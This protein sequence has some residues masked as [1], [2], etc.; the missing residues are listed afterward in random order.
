MHCP[1]HAAARCRSCTEL[2]VPYAAQLDAKQAHCRELLA[3]WPDLDWLPPVA[4]R[5]A[6]F[7]NKAKMVVS[8]SAAAPVL[9]IRD[10]AGRGVDLS[11][12]GLYPASLQACFPKIAAFIGRAA[13][14]PY[15][16][17]SRRGELK[18]V[19]LTEAPDRSLMLRF[20]LRSEAT[21]A[22]I[23]KHL[24]SLLADL[25]QLRVVS[26]NIQP[27]HKAVLEG[28]KELLL[29]VAPRLPMPVNGLNLQLRPQGFFQTNTAIA[30]ALYAQARDWITECAPATVWDLYCGVG[31]FALH[32]AGDGRRVTGVELEAEAIASADQAATEAGI[33]TVDWIAADAAVWALAQQ[34]AAEL[35]IVNPPR[36][37]IGAALCRRLEAAI[38]TRWLI[39]SS[40]NAES[41][42]RDLAAMPS[43][44]PR[45]ARVLDMFPQTRHYEVIV[46]LARA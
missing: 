19:L 25:P 24:P 12:C 34:T 36:R 14:D 17:A 29:S 38:D 33:T 10:E 4:S 7:R 13:L 32:A 15:D 45:R 2:A 31:G 1:H 9:G 37:G 8:G 27:E 23:R 43:Y 22:R 42:T 41:L 26:A 46:L 35:V 28:P 20:V 16:L 30:E 44:I 40:C 11:D 18:F 21:I 6:G 39:Y 3:A 5:D